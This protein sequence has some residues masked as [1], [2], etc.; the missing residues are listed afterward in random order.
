[1]KDKKPEKPIRRRLEVEMASLS[2]FI[3]DS[4]LSGIIKDPPTYE[5][6]GS[7]IFDALD[8][9]KPLEFINRFMDDKGKLQLVMDKEYADRFIS[10]WSYYLTFRTGQSNIDQFDGYKPYY[11]RTIYIGDRECVKVFFRNF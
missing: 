8:L 6:M 1:M 2:D 9:N 10:G 4:M 7:S 3:S 5:E 11:R